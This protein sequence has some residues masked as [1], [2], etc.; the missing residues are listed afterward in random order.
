[1]TRPKWLQRGT[2]VAV[3][4]PVT[5][6]VLTNEWSTAALV[7]ALHYLALL[8][9][10]DGVRRTLQDNFPHHNHS[11]LNVAPTKPTLF[12]GL[13]MI[14]GAAAHWGPSAVGE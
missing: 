11:P 14:V 8:E 3:G 10:S 12:V 7:H 9:F 4:V 5:L 2:T 1:M 13:G 6:L